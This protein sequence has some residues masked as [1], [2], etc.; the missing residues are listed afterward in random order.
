MG[1]KKCLCS[2][3]KEDIEK[4]INE[5]MKMVN[6]PKYVCKKC[7]RAANEKEFICKPVEIN[8]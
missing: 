5:I 1:D 7:A 6:T 2:M 3:K 4:R 8:I